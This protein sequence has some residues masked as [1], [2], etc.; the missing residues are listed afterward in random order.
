MCCCLLADSC[1]PQQY[2]DVACLTEQQHYVALMNNEVWEPLAC[3]CCPSTCCAA[4]CHCWSWQHTHRYPHAMS[5]MSTLDFTTV[6]CYQSINPACCSKHS[7]THLVSSLPFTDFQIRPDA[8][9]T[10][11]A[12]SLVPT[13]IWDDHDYIQWQHSNTLVECSC[14]LLSC[15][16]GYTHACAV[17]IQCRH[18][19]LLNLN[20]S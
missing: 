18:K 9:R 3:T 17:V 8:T 15:V 12:S 7:P 5:H 11:Y 16:V 10:S 19:A 14:V 6:W 13:C 2:H 1:L 4:S 20:A